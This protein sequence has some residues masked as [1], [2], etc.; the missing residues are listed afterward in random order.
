MVHHDQ[1]VGVQHTAGSITGAR[2]GGGIRFT[3]WHLVTIQ[4]LTIFK[5]ADSIFEVSDLVAKVDNGVVCIILDL[6]D[7]VMLSKYLIVHV[8]E[9]SME[10]QDLLSCSVNVTLEHPEQLQS[11][12]FSF[13]RHSD[14]LVLCTGC[15]TE[16]NIV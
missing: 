15:L 7:F 10:T 4:G 5:L 3:M 2:T 12:Q 14:S 16:R 6:L 1:R 11:S 9:F 8:I 13:K